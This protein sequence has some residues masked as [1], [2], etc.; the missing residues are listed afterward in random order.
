MGDRMGVVGGSVVGVSDDGRAPAASPAPA[1]APAGATASA[2]YVGAAEA[3]K[4]FRRIT[5]AD[6][7]IIRSKHVLFGSRSSGLCLREGL[8]LLAARNRMYALPISPSIPRP[9]AT[10]GRRSRMTRPNPSP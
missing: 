4:E 2:P 6:M 9:T 5:A 3:D 8:A 10:S 7:E 1:T